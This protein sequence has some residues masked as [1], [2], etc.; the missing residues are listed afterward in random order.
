MNPCRILFICTGNSARSILAE[1]TLNALGR[2]RFE[3]CSAGSQ[4]S[5]Y[6]HSQALTTL[7]AAGIPT[8]GLSSKSWNR[9]VEPGAYAL[10]IVITLCDRA[11][12]EPCP[13]LFGDF[14][15]GHWGLPDPAAV[16]GNEEARH[17]AFRHTHWHITKRLQALIAIPVEAMS[18]PTLQQEL[19]R[20]GQ[21]PDPKARLAE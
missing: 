8:D 9:F 14:I 4:P 6:V 3:A 10:D 7:H 15:R 1:A 20:I 16:Q 12:R 18:P 19:E 17:E 11:R 2:P 13:V 5:G 21:I